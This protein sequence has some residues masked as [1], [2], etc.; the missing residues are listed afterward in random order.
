MREAP[1]YLLGTFHLGPPEGYSLGPEFAEA[2]A[3]ATSLVCEVGPRD[4]VIDP[5]LLQRHSG[6]LAAEI[7]ADLYARLRADPRYDV[8]F[9]TIAPAIVV[10]NLVLPLYS[11]IGLSGA[12]GVDSALERDALIAGKS[13]SGFE[14]YADQIA[15]IVGID[16][17][18]VTRAF[19]FMLTRPEM[20]LEIR[21]VIV[22]SFIGGD[23]AGINA[24]RELTVSWSASLAAKMLSEREE[25]WFPRLLTIASAKEPTFV[26][27]GALHVVSAGGLVGRL[28]AAGIPMNR[29][30]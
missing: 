18:A 5:A 3:E 28:A 14:T 8:S 17:A 4:K 26:A 29:V 27:V 9:E 22:R 25:R 12:Y 16:Q 30:G 23:E 1:V 10:M 24:A 19:E 15:A 11:N 20:I 7:G 13:C 2:F 6:S 21:D